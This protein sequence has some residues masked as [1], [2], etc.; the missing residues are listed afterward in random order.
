MVN[1]SANDQCLGSLSSRAHCELDKG[2]NFLCCLTP[3]PSVDA[4]C[5]LTRQKCF[6]QILNLKEQLSPPSLIWHSAIRQGK[7]QVT[8]QIIQDIW[9]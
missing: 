7:Q 4:A 8:W 1:H 3:S 6:L 9:L 5:N 2:I